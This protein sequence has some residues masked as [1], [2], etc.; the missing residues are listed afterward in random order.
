MYLILRYLMSFDAFVD[1]S[2]APT[3]TM[4]AKEKH[5]K[6]FVLLNQNVALNKT[7][8]GS[9]YRKSMQGGMCDVM[10]YK[11]RPRRPELCFV[12]QS[13]RLHLYLLHDA[14]PRHL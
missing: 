13:G 5:T 12:G 14:E 1:I 6:S 4:P 10:A 11:K 8:G 7:S 3:F 2:S 9:F